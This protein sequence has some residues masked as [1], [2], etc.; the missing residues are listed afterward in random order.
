MHVYKIHKHL[1]I[2]LNV[3]QPFD[4]FDRGD[5]EIFMGCVLSCNDW[6][7]ICM[8]CK[9]FHAHYSAQARSLLKCIELMKLFYGINYP[10]NDSRISRSP[11]QD[12]K[13]H[14]SP[15]FEVSFNKEIK[16]YWKND[17]GALL[18]KT[19]DRIFRTVS[20]KVN[21]LSKSVVVLITEGMNDAFRREYW[22]AINP[23]HH[24][25][26]SWNFT[27]DL[28]KSKRARLQRIKTV[29]DLLELL[30]D[31]GFCFDTIYAWDY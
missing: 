25:L 22:I 14:T 29:A 7:K 6:L 2:R 19:R 28:P 31:P 8:V 4:F 17:R 26:G 24:E 27:L 23:T 15:S 12:L 5:A 3:M 20:V 18:M 16:F 11:L 1:R 30:G 21:A 13:T 10:S 9:R